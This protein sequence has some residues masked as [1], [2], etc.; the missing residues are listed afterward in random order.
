MSSSVF[1]CLLLSS[2][3][4]YCFPLSSFTFL[5][6]SLSSF[7]FLSLALPFSLSIGFLPFS[8]PYFPFSS[9]LSPSFPFSFVFTLPFFPFSSSLSLPGEDYD[10][11]LSSVYPS[12]TPPPP[13]LAPLLSNRNQSKKINFIL[14]SMWPISLILTSLVATFRLLHQ[15]KEVLTACPKTTNICTV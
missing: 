8:L 6:L 3:V 11:C 1:Y 7:T 4:F 13:T 2:I 12:L 9:F 5:C 14:T 10:I 15:G